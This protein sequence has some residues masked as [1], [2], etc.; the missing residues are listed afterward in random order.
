MKPLVSLVTPCY[1]A[2]AFID[3]HL[4]NVLA[5]TYRP[6][7]LILVDD[8]SCDGTL[9]RAESWRSRLEASG[10]RLVLLAQDHRGQAA[11][12]NRGLPAVTGMYVSWPDCD[13]LMRPDNLSRKVDYLE[14]H[15]EAGFVCCSVAN[16]AEGALDEVTSVTRVADTTDPWLFDRL[17]RDSGAYCLD[18]AYLA[19][20]SALFSSLGGRRIYESPAGQN[21]QLLLP[22]AY[23]WP[24]GFIDEPLASYVARPGSHSHS[25]ASY[26]QQVQRTRDFEALLHHVLD[27]MEMDPVDRER[28]GRYVDEKFLPRRFMLALG[29]GDR[30]LV[31]ESKAALRRARGTTV[32]LELAALASELGLGR[33]AYGARELL[34]RCRARAGRAVRRWAR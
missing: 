7:E 28:Y 34:L 27:A 12:I 11:A 10:A 32:S 1:N 2:E 9:D 24:C 15:P 31:R 14:S 3:R 22:L 5:Q 25:F 23:H 20:S 33:A 17:I 13:D 21:F 29:A 18:I 6:I 16:V 26:Q 8:G 4:A 19:R 30:E